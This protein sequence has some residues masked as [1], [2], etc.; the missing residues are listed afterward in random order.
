MPETYNVSLNIFHSSV[1]EDNVLLGKYFLVTKQSVT[2]VTKER[3]AFSKTRL[4]IPEK[5][6]LHQ[7]NNFVQIVCRYVHKILIVKNINIHR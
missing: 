5:L 4:L 2:D 1:D 3:L 6:K 7:R